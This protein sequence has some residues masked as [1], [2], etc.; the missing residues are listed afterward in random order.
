[1]RVAGFEPAIKECRSFALTNLAIPSHVLLIKLPPLDLY[2]IGLHWVCQAILYYL[3]FRKIKGM[4][5][6]EPI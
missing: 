4:T 3:I 6:I 2:K 5:G 1:M